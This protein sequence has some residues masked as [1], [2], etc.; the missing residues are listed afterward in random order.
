MRCPV[1]VHECT[2]GGVGVGG[3]RCGPTSSDH[4]LCCLQRPMTVHLTRSATEPGQ[5]A[6]ATGLWM[7]PCVP[8]LNLW[9][10]SVLLKTL[11]G[12]DFPVI[13]F[14]KVEVVSPLLTVAI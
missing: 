11:Q 2:V 9:T 14:L 10:L 5:G 8:V 13:R 6:I 1:A 3:Q 7:R 4:G 12:P